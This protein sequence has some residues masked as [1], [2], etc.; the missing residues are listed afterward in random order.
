[1][2]TIL[3]DVRYALRAMRLSPS[4]TFIAVFC[5]GLGIGATSTIF[6][7]VDVLFFRPPPGVADPASIVRPYIER[8]TGAVQTTV[9]GNDRVSFPDY[10]DMRDNN[11]TLS[12]LAAFTN[13]AL[14]VGR[15]DEAHSADGVEVT[16]NYFNV[17]GVRPALG[18]FFVA[19]EEAGP[20]SP[21]AVVISGV[22]TP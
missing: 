22:V 14:S 11:R 20:G 21:L 9:G 7:I 2:N 17:L 10:V 19:E 1:M 16:G 3:R 18:R 12:G 15:G 8:D 4:F 13:V 6:G 5:L